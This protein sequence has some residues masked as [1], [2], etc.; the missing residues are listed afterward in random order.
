MVCLGVK[1]FVGDFIEMLIDEGVCPLEPES[2][3]WLSHGL[4]PCSR[5]DVL[6]VLE[7]KGVQMVWSLII[8]L[9]RSLDLDLNPC[10]EKVKL[11]EARE[12]GGK[13]VGWILESS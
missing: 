13:K 11:C 4:V 12:E 6:E 7:C 1:K 10:L 3:K 5:N 9:A 8:L 2:D